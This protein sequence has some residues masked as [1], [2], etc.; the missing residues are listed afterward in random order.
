MKYLILLLSTLI[1]NQI[2]GQK[3][4]ECP[5]FNTINITGGELYPN[6]SY[7]YENNIYPL[8]YFENVTQYLDKFGIQIQSESHTRGCSCLSG[9]K[10][11]CVKVCCQKRNEDCSNLWSKEIVDVRNPNKIIGNLTDIYQFDYSGLVCFGKHPKIYHVHEVQ[12]LK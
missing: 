1:N 3:L 2:N 9:S 10:K 5:L 11:K 4:T 8:G 12:S 6:G 7:I